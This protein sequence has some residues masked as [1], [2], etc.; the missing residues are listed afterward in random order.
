MLNGLLF[1]RAI[2][3]RVTIKSITLN[4]ASIGVECLGSYLT[5]GEEA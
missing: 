2:A 5:E 4:D 1:V 3:I